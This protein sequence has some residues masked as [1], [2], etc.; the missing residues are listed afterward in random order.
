V[1]VVE[2]TDVACAASGKAGG[3]LARDWCDGAPLGRLARRGFELH[4][5]LAVRF[6]GAWDTGAWPR[7]LAEFMES[8]RAHSLTPPRPGYSAG[9]LRGTLSHRRLQP[10]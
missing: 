2:R 6:D 1:T 7:P 4:A 8:T 5:D 3:F 9:C 10:R